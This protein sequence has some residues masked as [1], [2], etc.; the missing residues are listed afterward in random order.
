VGTAEEAEWILPVRLELRL[1]TQGDQVTGLAQWSSGW[2]G[3]S[4]RRLAG[5]YV[6][7]TRSYELRDTAFTAYHPA[8]GHKNSQCLTTYSDLRHGADHRLAGRYSTRKPCYRGG[9]MKLQL[10]A[11]GGRAAP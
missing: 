2:Y 1:C 3:W 10:R 4:R 9:V 11:A 5:R 8:S 6:A 7:T